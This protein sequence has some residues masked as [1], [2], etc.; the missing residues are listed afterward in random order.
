MPVQRFRSFEEARRALWAE[1]GSP[2]IANRMR[3][4]WAFAAR[5]TTRRAPAGV[6]RFRT[7]E[8]AQHERATWETVRPPGS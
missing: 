5:L 2:D 8:E 1:S 6:R 3:L 4:L 7:L